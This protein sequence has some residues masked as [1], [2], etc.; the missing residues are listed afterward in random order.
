MK[1]SINFQAKG[2]IRTKMFSKYKIKDI[3]KILPKKYLY[4]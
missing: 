4:N 1:A 3:L 2:Q